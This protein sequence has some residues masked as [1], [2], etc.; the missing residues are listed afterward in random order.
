MYDLILQKII[1]K[2]IGRCTGIVLPYLL[3]I[4]IWDVYTTEKFENETTAVV[5]VFLLPTIK[6]EKPTLKAKYW[7]L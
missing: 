2:N 4:F 1:G 5:T 6:Y 7:I 3:Y